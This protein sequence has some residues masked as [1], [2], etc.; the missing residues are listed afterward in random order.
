MDQ[1]DQRSM[2]V[3]DRSRYRKRNTRTKTALQFEFLYREAI[4]LMQLVI[5][6]LAGNTNDGEELI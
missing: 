4:M 6:R 3:H 5:L 1:R 2:V